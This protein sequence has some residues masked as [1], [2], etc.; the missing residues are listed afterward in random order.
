MIESF[1]NIYGT[2][3]K[4]LSFRILDELLFKEQKTSQMKDFSKIMSKD[5]FL[6]SI[7]ACAIECVFFIEN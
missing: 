3:T 1:L 6:K 5:I 4:T 2:K 7:F